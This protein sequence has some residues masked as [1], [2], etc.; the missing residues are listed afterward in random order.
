[1]G[2]ATPYAS[3]HRPQIPRATSRLVLIEA[4]LA[5]ES[6]YEVP[7]LTAQGPGLWNFGFFTLQNG[8]PERMLAGREDTWVDGFIDW[9]EVVKGGVDEQAIAEYAAQLR[10][11]GHTRASFEYFRAFHADAT[12]AIHRR[13][14]PPTMPV[15][16]IGAEGTLGQM[17][18]DQVVR[19]ATD[20][21]GHIA[22]T[23]H[24][25]AEEDPAYLTARL[26][27]FL[28]DDHATPGMH[29]VMATA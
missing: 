21:T 28:T 17:V 19:Y 3:A 25:V 8:L 29:N 18:H 15:L 13:D 14:R 1:L 6:L 10:Q 22:P 20:V 4:P 9:L 26:L 2:A 16:A 27:T 7:S 23:G 5:D 11:P 12:E 24:W